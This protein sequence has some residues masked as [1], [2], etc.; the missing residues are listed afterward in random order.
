[1]LI[2]LLFGIVYLMEYILN[3]LIRVEVFS[4]LLKFIQ[5]ILSPQHFKNQKQLKDY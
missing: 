4:L 2:E 1:M 5:R 3:P